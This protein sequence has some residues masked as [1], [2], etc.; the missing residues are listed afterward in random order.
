[1]IDAA[2]V[3][4]RASTRVGL[5]TLAP[6]AF[7][8]LL[9]ALVGSGG[10]TGVDSFAASHLMP[11]LTPTGWN[12][13]RVVNRFADAITV[14]VRVDCTA[15]IGAAVLAVAWR[16]L[17]VRRWPIAFACGLA[18]ELAGK[19]LV[20]RQEL[21]APAWSKFDASFPSGSALRAVLLGA[22][23]ATAWPR[24]APAAAAYVVVVAVSLVAAGTHTPTDVAAGLVLGGL[25]A[26]A[27]RD[28]EEAG[29]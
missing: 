19:T 16:R 20:R 2:R 27:C 28:R 10:L 1:M 29:R 22:L 18:A 5:P 7:V 24:L 8:V 25:L 21:G 26:G 11:G 4:T 14:P 17:R 15:A 6:A 23:V 12:R 13:D 9:A 3:R